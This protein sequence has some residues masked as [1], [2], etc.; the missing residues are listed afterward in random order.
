MHFL[1]LQHTFAKNA[2]NIGDVRFELFVDAPE[3]SVVQTEV[4]CKIQEILLFF[5]K[6]ALDG[7][8]QSEFHE[9]LCNFV[10]AEHKSESGASST[11]ISGRAS[12]F[13]YP[14]SAIAALPIPGP[15]QIS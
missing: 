13:S 4:L 8:P 9:L 11:G 12:T 15:Y 3:K 5:G 1:L 7:V 6:P 10:F 2:V 14:F